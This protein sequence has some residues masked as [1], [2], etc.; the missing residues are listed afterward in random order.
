MSILEKIKT[1]ASKLQKNIVLPEG[2]D[3]RVVLASA[4]AANTGLAVV[5]LLGDE[6]AIE[7]LL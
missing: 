4:E 3:G 2:E 5:T 6:Q 1:E 7:A